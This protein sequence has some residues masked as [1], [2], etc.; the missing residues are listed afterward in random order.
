MRKPLAALIPMALLAACDRT[1][2]STSAKLTVWGD[3]ANVAKFVSSEQASR[4]DFKVSA[5]RKTADGS[6][7]ATLTF[8]ARL[9]QHDA[10][11]AMNAALNTNLSYTYTA[12]SSKVTYRFA[13]LRG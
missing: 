7:L 6:A 2:T 3:A 12:Q 1:S 9:G 10:K 8:P 5:T 13:G 11:D 4:S